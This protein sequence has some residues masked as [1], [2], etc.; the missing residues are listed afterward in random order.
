[1]E[2]WGFN[3]LSTTQSV[4]KFSDFETDE[5]TDNPEALTFGDIGVSRLKDLW[6]DSKNK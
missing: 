2:T 6:L 5:F 4:F 3:L 1:M